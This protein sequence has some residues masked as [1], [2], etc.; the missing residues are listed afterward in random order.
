MQTRKWS[1][2]FFFHLSGL[3]DLNCAD[4]TGGLH[5]LAKKREIMQPKSCSARFLIHSIED[6]GRVGFASDFSIIWDI[7]FDRRT[8]LTLA[9]LQ[10]LRAIMLVAC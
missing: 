4:S 9:S 7:W 6:I 1:A 3:H 10:V 5:D 8:W 2:R